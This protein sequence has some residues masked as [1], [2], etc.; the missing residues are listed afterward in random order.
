[1]IVTLTGPSCGGKSTLERA[2]QAR[3]YGRAISH[4]TREARSG[5]VCGEHYH[6]INDCTFDAMLAHGDFI[7]VIDLGTRRYAMSAASLELAA[8]QGNVVIV[9]EPHG[10]GQIHDYCEARKL[11][12]MG[13][14]I[15]CGPEEQAKRWLSRTVAEFA[16]PPSFAPAKL[17]A[18]IERLGLMLG[19][20]A[21]WRQEAKKHSGSA[22]HPHLYSYWITSHDIPAESLADEIKLVVAARVAES[23]STRG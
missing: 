14:W 3:G 10:A 9:V 17:D 5:E 2:L 21:A 23:S 4:T 12:V 15:D 13:V 22:L 11:P 8:Q 1:M 20:E 7:E 16:M 19:L 6:F 18:A